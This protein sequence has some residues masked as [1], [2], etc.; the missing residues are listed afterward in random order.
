MNLII[1]HKKDQTEDKIFTFKDHR[2]EHIINILKLSAGDRFEAG[3]INESVGTGTIKS[4]VDQRITLEYKPEE[5]EISISPE[6]DLI[7]ALPRPQT[8]KKVLFICGMTAI[9]R[10]HLI[11][12]NRVE[13]SYY[14]SPLLENENLNCHLLDGMSQGKNIRLTHVKVY[15]RFLPFVEDELSILEQQ[16]PESP[17]KLLPDREALDYLNKAYQDS[18]RATYV[19]IGPEGGWVPFEIEK[20]MAWG[21]KPIRLGNPVLRVEH[22]ISYILAQI[23]LMKKMNSE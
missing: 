10:L 5:T 15:D 6:I 4:I 16:E 21:F 12:A 7:C 9:R 13:K 2:A 18:P 17:L 19:A 22:A 3:L 23:E 1:L 8:L 14:H 11:R 20:F